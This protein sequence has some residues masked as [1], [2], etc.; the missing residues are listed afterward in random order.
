MKTIMTV[1]G[2]GLGSSFVVEMN[3][4]GLLEK[5]GM[6]GR[7]RTT[8]GAVYEVKEHDADYFVIAKDLEDIMQGFPNLIILNSIIDEDELREKLY[9]AL[10]G[11]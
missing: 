4:R 10:G 1:C 8:H 2:T 5:W 9:E 7:Y 6:S 11:R 3:V